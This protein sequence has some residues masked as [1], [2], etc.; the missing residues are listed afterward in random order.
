MIYFNDLK[1]A[2]H[3]NSELCNSL[4]HMSVVMC[5]RIA[6]IE[7]MHMEL[8]PYNDH[9][10]STDHVAAETVSMKN[11][12]LKAT[13]TTHHLVATQYFIEYFNRE[14]HC[15][16]LLHRKYR[17]RNLTVGSI[18]ATEMCF[19]LVDLRARFFAICTGDF[20]A[21]GLPPLRPV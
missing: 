17:S 8:W 9:G 20:Y 1:K 7:R 11:L 10:T 6:Q 18:V 2:R 21:P 16:E 14:H 15:L 5:N 4:T 3:F 12:V 19:Q 13:S